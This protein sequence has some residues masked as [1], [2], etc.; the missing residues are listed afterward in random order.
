MKVRLLH[1]QEGWLG[2]AKVLTMAASHLGTRW[3]EV[4]SETLQ[5]ARQQQLSIT[6]AQEAHTKDDHCCLHIPRKL[7]GTFSMEEVCLV[8]AYHLYVVTTMPAHAR[9][10]NKQTWTV[11][12]VTLW[13]FGLFLFSL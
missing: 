10:Q 9:H 7:Y 12:A 3:Y 11:L 1:L 4:P 2:G 5:P 6:S 8:G 13:V